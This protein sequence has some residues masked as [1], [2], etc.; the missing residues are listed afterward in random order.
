MSGYGDPAFMSYSP[1]GYATAPIPGQPMAGPNVVRTGEMA[2]WSTYQLGGA[3]TVFSTSPLSFFSTQLGQQGQGFTRNVTFPETNIREGSRI[4]SQF[5]YAVRALSA[6][7]YACVEAANTA[8]SC[9]VPLA[10]LLNLQN[11]TGFQ[12]D[13][14]GTTI[15]IAPLVA[16]G[17]GG[18][19]FGS[20]ADTG[21]AYGVNGSQVALNNG[22]GSV[23]VYQID[24]ILLPPTQTF[25]L[26][27]IAGA[28]C[29]PV[30]LGET[31][32]SV[33]R[34]RTSLYGLFARQVPQG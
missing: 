19:A 14:N 13:L 18:G 28:D 3:G 25:N 8:N 30:R 20:T 4:P 15:D 2:Y 1:S 26:K 29:A 10:D 6:Q 33:L 9:P 31:N 32:N 24:P 27:L 11:Q 12:W 5:G 23:W 16:V 34:L 21:G 22:N 17:A 7:P